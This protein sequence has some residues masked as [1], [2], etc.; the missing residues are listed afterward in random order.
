M[1]AH[2]RA[3][4][5]DDGRNVEW[6]GLNRAGTWKDLC[7]KNGVVHVFPGLLPERFHSMI[8]EPKKLK[9]STGSKV[10]LGKHSMTCIQK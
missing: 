3:C 5:E 10:S 1:P 2:A 8:F 9:C 7:I 6:R 4:I